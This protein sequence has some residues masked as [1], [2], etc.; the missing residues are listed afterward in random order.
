VASYDVFLQSCRRLSFG[1]HPRKT[2]RAV[3]SALSGVF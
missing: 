3:R 1:G 2:L